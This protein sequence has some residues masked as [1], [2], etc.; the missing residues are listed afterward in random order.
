VTWPPASPP[1]ALRDR[2]G[3]PGFLREML[4]RSRFRQ[5]MWFSAIV[6]VLV[7]IGVGWRGYWIAGERPVTDALY[8][9][10]QVFGLNHSGDG[11][12]P[13]IE[14]ARFAGPLVLLAAL[15]KLLAGGVGEAMRLAW[16]TRA[17]R[18]PRDVVLG[19]GPKGREIGRRLIAQGRGV[20]WIAQVHGADE[21]LREARDDAE[22]MGGYLLI[23]D[24]SA[25]A[26]FVR[27]RLVECERAFFAL[28]NDLA[29]LDAAEALHC[30]LA[31][32]PPRWPGERWIRHWGNHM[33]AQPASEKPNI[34][35]FTEC[36]AI[37][38]DLEHGATHG[39]VSGRD[40]SAFNLRA[41]AVRRLVLR[42]RF[43]RTALLLGQERVHLV[44]A[45]F[46]WQGEALLEEALLLCH[47]AALKPPLVT[48]LERDAKAARERLKRRSP[49]LFD[50]HLAI[51][52]WL[53]PRFVACDLETVDFA[54]LALHWCFE[55]PVPVT[56]W[57]LC[58][59]DD[60]LNLRASLVLQ[61]AMQR[62]AL[63]GAAIYAR[64][65]AG[66]TGEGHRL[67]EDSLTQTN[68]F[69]GLKDAL[70]QT[71]ALAADPDAAA[72]ALHK[73]Y[74]VTEASTKS[75]PHKTFKT[76]EEAREKAVENWDTLSVSKR[77]SN[78]RAHRHAA[79]KLADLGYDWH[80]G[81]D[82]RLPQFDQATQRPVWD[83]VEKA[84]AERDFTSPTGDQESQ[85]L[86]AM[87]NEHDR[88]TIDRA[89][90]GWRLATARDEGRLL[91]TDMK[92]FEDLD[93]K[94]G[95]RAYDGL[96]LRALMGA[97]VSSKVGPAALLHQRVWID[98]VHGQPWRASA[99]SADWD[100]ATEFVITLPTGH[101]TRPEKTKVL[102]DAEPLRSLIGMLKAVTLTSNNFCRL[103]LVFPAP[104]TSHVLALANALAKLAWARGRDV[105]ALWAWGAGADGIN[106]R[107]LS[108]KPDLSAEA[109]KALLQI[110]NGDPAVL[111]VTGH[112]ALADPEKA[113]ADLEAALAEWFDV[114]ASARPVLL[115]GYALGVDRIAFE[116]WT[117]RGGKVKLVFPWADNES[118]YA[119]TDQPSEANLL[120]CRIDLAQFAALTKQ[121]RLTTEVL[122]P[123]NSPSGHDR[124]AEYIVSNADHLIAAWDQGAELRLGGTTD[125]VRRAFD[126]GLPSTIV[127]TQRAS[128][129]IGPGQTA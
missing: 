66:Q 17:A 7:V 64:V 97:P 129:S 108:E 34:R 63:P 15:I 29:G 1:V 9:A 49:A 28:E 105:H 43:D 95:V 62:R 113:R 60:D 119:W 75:I 121:E 53:P 71:D 85:F 11:G 23:G 40:V 50:P 10:I 115:C 77:A 27:A 45:G 61:T 116:Y 24:P 80:A 126:K 22:V 4:P 56:A 70:D 54:A 6:S 114:D 91:H 65:W 118:N 79:A 35:L 124:V 47:R 67:G 84:L 106:A 86:S 14:F 13:Y 37:Q 120:K 122:C 87:I 111:A 96:L 46:G 3:L 72:K 74:L 82:E 89:V 20:T 52:G 103:V 73:A 44:I 94:S 18:S 39:F 99:P 104:P 59:G 110:S 26:M 12:N 8:R 38:A 101:T 41:E 36:P 21:A 48:V 32:Q 81:E 31:S 92:R 125:T 68:I 30:W 117:A 127:P 2:M 16:H 83:M 58:A 78:R 51:E 88:W 102:L 33:A 128:E 76:V 90:D 69:G 107:T 123:F 25:P 19:F 109:P 98:L 112:I 93:P 57:A 5:V 55:E 100:K 42:A